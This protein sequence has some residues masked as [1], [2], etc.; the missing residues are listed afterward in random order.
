MKLP[1]LW[2]TYAALVVLAALAAYVFL[3]ERKKPEGGDAKPKEKVFTLDKA[4]V[5][6]LTIA[7]TAGE[8]IKLV[9]EG[10]GWKMT[11]PAAVPADTAAV[12]SMIS[13]LETLEIDEV[14][15]DNATSLGDFGLDKPKLQVEAQAQGSPQPSKLLLG[16]KLAD[17]SG[18]YAKL[19]ASNRV[20]TVAS[21]T[22]SS[23]EK[24]PFDLR[25][26]DLLHVKRE[27]VKTLEISGPDGAY[28]VARAD[29]DEWAFTKPLVTRAGRWSVDS[30]LGALENLRMESVAAEAAQ[31]LKPF[32][33]VK[34]ARAVTIGLADGTAK[35]LEIGGPAGDAKDKKFH[36]RVSGASL[37]AVIPGA[38]V[39]DLAKGMKE[40]RAKRLLEVATYEVQGFDALSGSAKKTCAKSTGKDKDGLEKA[41]WKR[42][43]PDAKDLDTNKV[44]DALFRLGGVEVQEFIDQPK[45]ASAYGL[46]APVFKLVL[47]MGAGKGEPSVEL[48]KKDGAVYARRP[49]DSSVLKLDPAKADEL[50]KGFSEL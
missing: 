6:E 24:K 3:V 25:D 8:T 38:L 42:T 39:D 41:Q 2:K 31:E 30:L 33:L 40:L 34:P 19:P 4:K 47:R 36:A 10:T 16:A 23:F 21:W 29:K 45:E 26:R 18:V 27:N 1:E 17:G 9:R 12:D 43:A 37:V 7:S 44:E 49:G 35:T 14:V 32:G 22:T 28:A 50:I 13:S 5:G 46:D 15:A 48:G 11:A 20:F